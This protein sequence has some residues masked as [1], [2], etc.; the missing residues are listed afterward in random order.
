M[1]MV[2]PFFSA[3]GLMRLVCFASTIRLDKDLSPANDLGRPAQ[4]HLAS[5]THRLHATGSVYPH[6][7]FGPLG[8]DGSHCR[9]ARPRARRLRF[10]NSAFEE[11]GVDVFLVPDP[12]ELYIDSVLE[13]MML[14]DLG[15]VALPAWREVVHKNHEVRVSH[16][17]RNPPDFAECHLNRQFL[18]ALR[19]THTALEFER[20]S[21][22]RSH[23]TDFHPP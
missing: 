20:G 9:R 16:G 23:S 22:M 14:A 18:S 12:H 5:P 13:V 10:A 11:L 19:L 17:N 6:R 2:S 4:E 8:E 7:R 3:G 15:S 21:A 1:P